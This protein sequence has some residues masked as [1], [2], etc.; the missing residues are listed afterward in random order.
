MMR[1]TVYTLSLLVV[2]FGTVGCATGARTP[3]G[4][5]DVKAGSGSPC[6]PVVAPDARSPTLD[7]RVPIAPP[8]RPIAPVAPLAPQAALP[9]VPA[10]PA[11]DRTV[12]PCEPVDEPSRA[13][14]CAG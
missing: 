2:L 3:W 1:R 10:A 11:A 12:G 8:V 4:N 6:S 14:A 7:R 5:L 9:C 13:L